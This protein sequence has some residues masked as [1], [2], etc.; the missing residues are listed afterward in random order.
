MNFANFTGAYLK[1]QVS[2]AS[3]S[4]LALEHDRAH[5]VFL[6]FC[7]VLVNANQYPQPLRNV[8]KLDTPTVDESDGYN[9][10]QL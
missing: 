5:W 7:Y 8:Y 2:S 1:K 4:E 10:Q 3:L 9:Q 6:I